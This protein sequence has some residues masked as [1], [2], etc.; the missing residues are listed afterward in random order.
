MGIKIRMART[1]MYQER[2][3]TFDLREGLTEPEWKA[4][5]Q[6]INRITVSRRDHLQNERAQI[7]RLLTDAGLPSPT[8]RARFKLPNQS[9]E[10][11]IAYYV[12]QVIGEDT[13]EYFA[14]RA[15]ELI[16][17][18]LLHVD[19]EG[20]DPWMC[21][22]I[23]VSLGQILAEGR[24]KKWEPYALND[25]R[26]KERLAVARSAANREASEIAKCEHEKWRVCAAQVWETHPDFTVSAVGDIVATKLKPLFPY[27][28][29]TDNRRP[30][31][32]KSIQP[33]IRDLKPK[34]A[35]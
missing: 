7:A 1:G 19:R 5:W 31:K 3:R 4:L 28:P 21:I 35:A 24:L 2:Q 13:Q 25:H 10:G 9:G 15:I 17:D 16:D 23:A 12:K 6:D 11:G 26:T 18:L 30:V 20:A 29:T 22:Y 33:V 14:A 27:D 34:K 8:P 32:G